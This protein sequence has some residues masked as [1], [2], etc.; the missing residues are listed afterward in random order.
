MKIAFI[1]QKGI[2][3]RFGGVER[4]VEELSAKLADKGHDV[5]VYARKNY[6]PKEIKEHRG[7]KLIHLPNIATKHLDAITH[8]FFACFHLLGKKVDI[9]HFHSIGPSLL[10][11]LVKLLKPGVPIVATFHTL[12]YN[13]KKW[14]IAG[15]TALRLGERSICYFP[16]KTIT[17]SKVLNQYASSKYGRSFEYVPNGVG[18]AYHKEPDM[19][20]KW[21]LEKGN[22]I[23]SVSRLVRHKGIHYLINSFKSLEDSGKK[24]VIAGDGAYTDDYV[25]E[26]K[27][28]AY[29]NPN[30]IFT[31]NQT[32]DVLSELYTNAYL[33][34]QPS[35]SEGLSIALLEALSYA[36]AVLASDIPE[37]RE[38]VDNTGFLY[39]NLNE[40][41]LRD[42]LQ[43]LIDHPEILDEKKGYAAAFVN[44]HYNWENISSTIIEIYKSA[45]IDKASKKHAYNRA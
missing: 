32:G 44:E 13:H 8:T 42:K 10:I 16:D 38:V 36:N 31:G 21:G 17:I 3:A 19:I 11:W 15:K 33:F 41:D 24:L 35:E 9:I 5:F 28:L 40:S 45:I 18:E 12:C 6:T 26:L 29:N 23:L 25:A 37:N 7:V 4:H 1:G 20:K 43:H 14:G 22:Y 2:P 39:E 27:A 34:V 30:I